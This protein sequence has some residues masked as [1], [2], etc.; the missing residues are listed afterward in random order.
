MLTICV[1][2]AYSID[3]GQFFRNLAI[4]EEVEI[5]NTR[6]FFWE[7]FES[8]IAKEQTYQLCGKGLHLNRLP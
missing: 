7:Y 4:E 8:D 3:F 1:L 5:S 2:V 6:N